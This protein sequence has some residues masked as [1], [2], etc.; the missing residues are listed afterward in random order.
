[1]IIKG[2]PI[3][4]VKEK[5]LKAKIKEL[6]SMPCLG[7]IL[8]GKNPASLIYVKLKEKKAKDLGIKIKKLEFSSKDSQKKIIEA[9]EKLKKNVHGLIVQLPLPAKFNP[10][11]ILEHIPPQLDVDGFVKN[12]PFS[13]PAHQAIL[14]LIKKALKLKKTKTKKALILANSLVFAN[15]LKKQLEKLGIKTTI[16][17]KPKSQSFSKFD[18]I[19]SALGKPNFL[20]PEMVKRGSIL[21]DFGYSR[22]KGKPVGDI[23][24]KCLKKNCFLSPVPGG[25]GPLTVFFLLNNVY[26]AAK[27]KQKSPKIKQ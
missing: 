12:S 13:P 17:I 10:D 21:I 16:L 27:Y 15:P 24:K 26:L 11:K 8:I 23:D 22:K 4:Q 2:K 20:K 25:V 3:V 7:I 9:I 5:I 1:M 19:I 18:L 14:C 6:K